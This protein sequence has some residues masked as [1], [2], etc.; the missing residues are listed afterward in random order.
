MEV[1]LRAILVLIF[2]YRRA[3]VQVG[4]TNKAVMASGGCLIWYA[5]GV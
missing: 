2:K 5:I 4:R 1:G 3:I